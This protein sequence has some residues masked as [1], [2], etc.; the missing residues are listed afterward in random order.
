MVRRVGPVQWSTI[1]CPLPLDLSPPLNFQPSQKKGPPLLES[2][3]HSLAEEQVVFCT[4]FITRSSNRV[5][6]H[7]KCHSITRSSFVIDLEW[8]N[9]ALSVAER[10]RTN[11]AS[12]LRG[13]GE[14]ALRRYILFYNVSSSHNISIRKDK[15]DFLCFRNQQIFCKL[16]L[17]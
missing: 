10:R 14:V 8:V 9:T 3:R 5:G 1:K 6:R 12:R 16:L 17:F 4:H 2:P 11:C 13:I 7:F 15:P